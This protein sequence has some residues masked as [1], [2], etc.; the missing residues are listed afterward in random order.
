MSDQ[1]PLPPETPDDPGYVQVRDFLLYGLSLPERTL[2]SAAGVVSGSMRESAS[3]LVPAAFQN[4][5]CYTTMVRQMLDFLAEDVGGV[6]RAEE[7]GGPPKVENYVARKAVGNFIELSSLA[8]FHLSPF[9]LLAIVS[10]VP[11]RQVAPIVFAP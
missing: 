9:L 11:G 2:R 6:E 1:S 4:S 5:R 8:T 10:D 7:A 3:L